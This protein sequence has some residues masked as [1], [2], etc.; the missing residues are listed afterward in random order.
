MPEKWIRVA[1]KNVFYSPDIGPENPDSRED[2]IRKDLMLR[3]KHACEHLSRVDFEA[4]VSKMTHEQLRG[5]GILG[6][7]TGSC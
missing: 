7:R 3:L 1:G 4:L 2:C 6:R 5:E